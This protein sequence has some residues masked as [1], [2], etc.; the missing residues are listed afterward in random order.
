M[1]GSGKSTVGR[2]I[3]E[4]TGFEFFDGDVE[5]EKVHG[6]RQQFL[7][8]NGAQAYVDMEAEIIM[9]FPKQHVVIAPGGSIIYSERAL[10]HFSDVYKVFLRAEF[11]TVKER[12][13][14]GIGERGI[15]GLKAHGL[16]A[17][18]AQ[19]NALYEKNADLDVAIEGKSIEEIAKLVVEEYVL[20]ALPRSKSSFSSTN[21][22]STASFCQAMLQ[23]LA[24]DKGLFVPDKITAFTN[25]DMAL[26]KSL[27]YSALAFAVMRNFADIDDDSLRAMCKKAYTFD[28]GV[29]RMDGLWI[30]RLDRGPSASFK[31]FAAQLLARMMD[32]AAKKEL[33][34][35]T[36]TSGDTGGAVAA[37][38]KESTKARVVLLM[39]AGEITEK[40]RRQMTTMGTNVKCI[41]VKGTFD[42]CQA[43]A[44]E[45]FSSMPGL[46]SA[47]SINI[48]RLLPQIVYYFY[49]Y[50]R[51]G[52]N[53]FVVPSGNFGNLVAGLI[54][55]K[56]GLPVRFIAAVNENDEFPRFLQTGLYA[57]LVPSRNCISNAMNVGNPSN[58]SRLFYLYGGTLDEVG[59]VVKLPDMQSLKEDV[60][61]VSITDEETR[62]AM[63]NACKKGVVLEPHGAVG[64]AAASKISPSGTVVLLETAHP[65]KFSG[66]LDALGIRYS[67]PDSLKGL[68][69]LEENYVVIAPD[70]GEL[71]KVLQG[72][73]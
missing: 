15:V 18:Y 38:F 69:N 7:D 10:A 56:M 35:L 66:E 41:L 20:H 51:T 49:I 40:Q 59:K 30:A 31:D 14:A 55:R 39:P 21:G 6:N 73:L 26:L 12:L 29:E 8:K 24:G 61:S 65:A 50:F 45:A 58:L 63:R 36:A 27:S 9:R 46:S 4:I 28:I 72:L 34:I 48:G 32:Y 22:I 19:R 5:I 62:Q 47:N 37:A 16:E 42:D 54:A 33:I 44:K 70:F 68:E 60:S 25:E 43:L 11:G 67:V 23:G 64:Y 3:A 17:I 1:P 13:Q 2:K 53:T 71:K 52:A 57:P